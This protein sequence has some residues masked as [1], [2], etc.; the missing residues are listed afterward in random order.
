MDKQNTPVGEITLPDDIFNVPVRPEILHHVVKAQLAAKR[1]GT[2]GVKTRSQT[3]GGGR[4]PWRQKG[5]GR[6]RAG[7]VRSPLWTGG[8]VTHGPTM[9]DYSIKVNKKV[10]RLAMR[11][12]LSSKLA[13]QCLVVVD[14]MTLNSHKTQDFVQVQKA[15]K[16]EKGLI[17]VSKKDN[18]LSLGSRNVPGVKVIEGSQLGVYDILNTQI[19]VVT[20]QVVEHLQGRLQ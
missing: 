10:K 11:M 4:K 9:R 5:T 7:S 2:V 12:A 19:L 14:D 18:N 15:L 1:A 3:R 13:E 6:A 20:P 8:A 16:L 17:V